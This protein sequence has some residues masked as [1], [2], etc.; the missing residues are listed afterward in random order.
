MKKNVFSKAIAVLA[1]MTVLGAASMMSASAAGEGIAIGDVEV[2]YGT[3]EVSVP[4]SLLGGVTSNGCEI[5]IQ[6]AA[7]LSIAE[8]G[9][10]MAF[11]GDS[12]SG[13]SGVYASGGA[14]K[15]TFETLTVSIDADAEPG[16]Y[17]I[18]LTITSLDNN[19][20]YVEAPVATSGSVTILEEETEATEATT[21]APT[22]AETEAPATEAP[23]A[24][25]TV[26]ATTKAAAKTASPKT[27]T[28]GV[29]VAVAG[30]VTAGATAVV[31]KKKK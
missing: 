13:L 15:T 25:T 7:P 30:L 12:A 1:S 24:A 27:G 8:L 5:T 20:E 6:C 26:A 28:A 16:V 11:D 29:A 21:E 2:A 4:V 14:M 10:A 23:V 22:A 3:T 18:N 9:S 17:P 19:G 31:L